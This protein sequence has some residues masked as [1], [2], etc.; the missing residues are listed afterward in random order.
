MCFFISDVMIL[1]LPPLAST[2]IDNTQ[3]LDTQNKPMQ[4]TRP[5]RRP[6]AWIQRWSGQCSPCETR[7]DGRREHVVDVG[8]TSLSPGES[9]ATRPTQRRGAIA[10]PY[11]EGKAVLCA[12]GFEHQPPLTA[13]ASTLAAL[14]KHTDECATRRRSAHPRP[15]TPRRCGSNA[16]GIGLHGD[17][18]THTVAHPPAATTCKGSRARGSLRTLEG[19]SGRVMGAATTRSTGIT[20]ASARHCADGGCGQCKT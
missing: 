6:G 11:R 3:R 13:A 20:F 4:R 1:S 16:A 2:H 9:Q 7:R 17:Q 15:T 14:S 5:P 18:C 8:P 19:R 12:H 10:W